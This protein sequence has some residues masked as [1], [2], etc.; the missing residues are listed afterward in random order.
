MWAVNSQHDPL[1]SLADYLGRFAQ[2]FL[3]AAG[4]RCRPNMPAP[5]PGCPV[6]SRLR[7]HLFLA[8]EEVLN[9]VVKHAAATEMRFAQAVL[10]DSIELTMQ[11]NGRGSSPRSPAWMHPAAPPAQDGDGL[12]NL[13]RR[14][15]DPGGR[16]EINSGADG[17]L[18][19]F[20][21]PLK[22]AER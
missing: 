11:D 13:R 14:F 1:D 19:R 22:R 12:R 3:E 7:H 15:E 2:D 8:L 10:A 6:T 16:C 21:V 9:S 18:G 5:Q 20:C 17:T 4:L